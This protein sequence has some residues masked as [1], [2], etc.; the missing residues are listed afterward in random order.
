[1]YDERWAHDNAAEKLREAEDR[2]RALGPPGGAKGGE[3]G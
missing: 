1:M 3:E 2:I